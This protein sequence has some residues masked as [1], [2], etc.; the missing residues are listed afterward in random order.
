M[1][2]SCS[3]VC[4]TASQPGTH[5]PTKGG[6]HM[7]CALTHL[8]LLQ[9]SDL[10]SAASCAC[11][12]R[13]GA[14]LCHHDKWPCFSNN[15][16]WPR[17]SHHDRWPCF[18]NNGTQPEH[19]HTHTHGVTNTTHTDTHRHSHLIYTHSTHKL[20]HRNR[21][22]AGQGSSA[23]RQV[24]GVQGTWAAGSHERRRPRRIQRQVPRA[25]CQVEGGWSRG[26]RGMSTI[27]VDGVGGRGTGQ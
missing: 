16:R 10:R 8:E 18:S 24:K 22:Y 23:R 13:Q 12:E 15:D 20:T 19:T 21:G 7:V 11:T 5:P 2:C 6:A 14:V 17:F 27:R 9:S 4:Q 26:G 3:D 1:R 25:A